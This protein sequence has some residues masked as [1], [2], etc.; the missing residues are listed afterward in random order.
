MQDRSPL[1]HQ[2]LLATHGRTIHWVRTDKTDCEHNESGY[3][4]IADIRADID[5]CRLVPDSDICQAILVGRYEASA[6]LGGRASR[7]LRL[8][9]LNRPEDG[10]VR[11]L[12][13]FAA[14]R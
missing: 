2:N 3:P 5:G 4:S 11:C 7:V 8:A 14:M 9:G 13:F 10:P 12:P 6:A 1:T